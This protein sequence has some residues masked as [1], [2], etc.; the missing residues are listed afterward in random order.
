[1]LRAPRLKLNVEYQLRRALSLSLVFSSF[2]EAEPC[3]P[4]FTRNNS[5]VV[6]DGGRDSKIYFS[7]KF[8]GFMFFSFK[9]G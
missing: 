5:I 1:M 7:T 2:P 3:K 8:S 6:I 4:S 9:R